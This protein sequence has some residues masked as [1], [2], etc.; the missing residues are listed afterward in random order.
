MQTTFT[1]EPFIMRLRHYEGVIKVPD[2]HA[3]KL[4]WI[5]KLNEPVNIGWVKRLNEPVNMDWLNKLRQ[6]PKKYQ[7]GLIRRVDPLLDSQRFEEE[8]RLRTEEAVKSFQ[9]VRAAK[10]AEELR[11]HNE[12]VEVGQKQVEHLAGL[13]V[14]SNNAI[15]QRNAIIRFMVE[16]MVASDQPKEIK[17]KKLL[18]YSVQFA[19]LAGGA[20]D[21]MQIIQEAIEKL[22]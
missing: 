8:Q 21:V 11:R 15:E 6:P 14:D 22:N 20:N 18:E 10:E 17:K 7:G 19:T 1:L 2:N 9:R 16:S 13:L 12:L 4:K 5:K 3:S